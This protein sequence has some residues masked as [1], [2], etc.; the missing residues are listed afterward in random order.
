M[1]PGEVAKREVGGGNWEDR[2][3]LVVVSG[4]EIRTVD[5]PSSGPF[6]IG[7][8]DGNALRIDDPGVSRNHAVLHIDAK[9][10]IEDLGSANGTLLRDRAHPAST[11]ETLN[12]RQLMG[13]KA[14]LAVGDTLMF[15][16]S[17]VVV[18]HP[19]SVELPDL[20]GVD[21]GVIVHDAGM[22]VVYEQARRA[23]RSQ[24]SVLVLGETGVGKE[25]LARAIHQHS[26]RAAGPFTGINCAAI[27]ESLLESE[28]F[29]SQKG[30]F[31]GATQARP[32]LFEAANG[33]TV[34][35]DEVGELAAPTQAKLLR[36]IEE[37]A[38]TRLGSTQP[39]AIDVRFV[40]ATNRDLEADTRTGR[41]RQDLFFRLNGISLLIPPLRERRAELELFVGKFLAA[42]CAQIERVELP[43]ISSAALDIMRAYTWP[44]NVRELRNVV[45]R[46]AVLCVGDTIAPEHLPPS[47]TNGR[48]AE[49]PSHPLAPPAPE[50]TFAPGDLQAEIRELERARITEVLAQ[51]G[52]NQSE[53]ARSLR[54]SRGTLVSRLNQ[55]GLPRPRKR[56]D[57]S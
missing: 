17:S 8:G 13:Q 23:A 24:L 45:E 47:L 27:S 7:R 15:G 21:A 38:V 44:G 53:A 30:A 10:V 25:L 1:S 49:R 20:A 26:S 46:A 34:F 37:R 19:A 56:D 12:V 54:I 28:L 14:A 52:G 48:E 18:R 43:M 9:L 22:R 11:A 33:G 2:L 5:L 39:S 40:A 35:L 16:T 36:V 41:F 55:F 50:S 42:A 29:G 4:D 3:Q 31:T 6:T 57:R 51:H 32:G